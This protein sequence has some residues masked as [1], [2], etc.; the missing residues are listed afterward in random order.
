MPAGASGSPVFVGRRLVGA[1]S[2]LLG[3]DPFLV[4]ITPIGA[5]RKLAQEPD[6]PAPATI[7]KPFGRMGD[8][9]VLA[10]G[11]NFKSRE[12]EVALRTH[13]GGIPFSC[14]GNLPPRRKKSLAPG[15]PVG[16]AMMIGDLRLGF[17]GTVTYVKNRAVYAFGHPL[18]HSGPCQYPLTAATILTTARGNFP[19]K[20][21]DLGE[22]MGTVLQ[23]RAAGVFGLLGQM[24][25][26]LVEG[27]LSVKDEDRKVE[28]V[29]RVQVVHNPAELPF[30]I[31]VAALE[32]ITQTMNRV[33]EGTAKWEWRVHIRG[34]ADE[35]V[36][37]DEQYSPFNIGTVVADSVFSLLV[38]PLD[39]DRQVT[40]V[41]LTARF[42]MSDELN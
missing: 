5:M 34:E 9:L 14:S 36:I 37:M 1:V 27:S 30:L 28:T 42:T 29:H 40:K 15:D 41:A 31:Y 16:V 26:G 17:I 3:G 35:T 18:L 19:N 33:G 4:G 38:E 10:V 23:D 25:L 12:S 6:I 8:S 22:V 7:A 11:G 2:H 13:L 39:M 32:T 20:I 24:P 21:G